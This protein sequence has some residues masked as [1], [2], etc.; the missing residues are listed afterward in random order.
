M[1]LS[2][3][4]RLQ[5]YICSNFESSFASI[6]GTPGV[7][8][9]K[10]ECAILH[11]Q[12]HH[13][14]RRVVVIKIY[15]CWN[16]NVWSGIRIFTRKYRQFTTKITRYQPCIAMHRMKAAWCILR[17]KKKVQRNKAICAL[18]IKMTM[19]LHPL[20]FF[21]LSPRTYSGGVW[22]LFTSNS[23]KGQYNMMLKR[24]SKYHQTQHKRSDWWQTVMGID[25][26]T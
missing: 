26:V 6:L 9:K 1:K 19:Q 22:D 25:N 4:Y 17:S 12:S 13:Q 2:W 20:H 14:A 11:A 7:E 5:V 3:G 10:I 24:L 15:K 16:R 18:S 8:K 23:M 21:F